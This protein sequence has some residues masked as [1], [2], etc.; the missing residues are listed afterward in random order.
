MIGS[1]YDILTAAGGVSGKFSTQSF[2]SPLAYVTPEILYTPTAVVF[3]L[4]VPTNSPAFTT[5]RIYAANSFVTN[6]ALFG[7]M[8]SVLGGSATTGSPQQGV[9]MQA[10]GSFGA[11][12]GYDTNEGGFVAGAGRQ[13]NRH[14]TIGAALSSLWTGTNGA[15]SSVWGN[16]VGV[17]GYGIYTSGRFAATEIAGGGHLSTSTSRFLAGVGTG[18]NKSDGS[19]GDAGAELQYTFGGPRAFVTPYASGESS[20]PAS[21]MRPKLAPGCST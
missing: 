18:D 9:W 8:N 2:S 11:A 20:I 13:V 15:G 14:L 6:Q 7:V 1:K 3:T 4:G 5:G 10:L 17:Y 21:V 12:N 19:F 16:S